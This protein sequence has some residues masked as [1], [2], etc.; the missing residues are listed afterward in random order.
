M[1]FDQKKKGSKRKAPP[2]M[3]SIEP[4]TVGLKNQFKRTGAESVPHSQ[5]TTISAKHRDPK[6]QPHYYQVRRN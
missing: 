3:A 6:Q 2:T 4:V 5:K 1:S